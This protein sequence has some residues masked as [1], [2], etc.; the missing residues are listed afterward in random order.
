MQGVPFLMNLTSMA[1]LLNLRNNPQTT[2]QNSFIYVDVTSMGRS[3]GGSV[4]I[5][6]NDHG[7]YSYFRVSPAQVS[8]DYYFPYVVRDAGSIRNVRPINGTIVVTSG[9]NG[10]ALEVCYSNGAYNFFHDA[11]GRYM[12]NVTAPGTTV[13]RIEANAYWSDTFCVSPSAMRYAQPTIYFICVYK[14][15]FWHVGAFGF[16]IKFN[17]TGE[18]QIHSCFS[19]IGGCY[20]GYFNDTIRLIQR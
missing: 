10:C 16:R 8:S 4:L 19:P 9:M 7:I 17:P 15:G 13:C 2:I 1:L 14:S 20:R 6:E 12:S 18:D 3:N 5:T 11:D